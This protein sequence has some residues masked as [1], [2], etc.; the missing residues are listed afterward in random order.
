MPDIVLRMST[1]QLPR[2]ISSGYRYFEPG[3]RHVNRTI[4]IC[5]LVMVLEGTLYYTQDGRPGSVSA[6]QWHIERP[7][8]CM[9]G[10]RPCPRLRFY[11]VHFTALP[12]Q[13]GT[14][15][16]EPVNPGSYDEPASGIVSI[17]VRGKFDPAYFAPIFDRL[18]HMKRTAPNDLVM[19]Q[20]VF[21][22]LLSALME[23]AR[24]MMDRESRL[25]G[26]VMN[27]LTIHF[28]EG[29]KVESLKDVFHFSADY[30]SRL[31]RAHYGFTAKEYI[32]QLRLKRAMELLSHTSIPVEQV[33]R[34]AGYGD[35]TLFYRT[36][37]SRTG[38]TPASWRREQR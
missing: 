16:F 35:A 36:F 21:L 3:K 9:R 5:V 38:R 6:G 25:A 12:W 10:D 17:P 37:K 8:A 14:V 29:I 11:Y 30:L 1:E 19:Q 24:P 27:Y 15:G 33:A 7:N 18:E 22:G 13:E 31:M 23:T 20:G 34:M 4:D 32:Q 2:Y 28:D 26:D